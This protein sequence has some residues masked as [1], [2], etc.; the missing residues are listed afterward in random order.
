VLPPTPL[1]DGAHMSADIVRALVVSPPSS[2]WGA[3]LYLLDQVAPLAQRGI[4]LTLATPRDSDFARAWTERGH[5]VHPLPLRLHQGLR[6]P[7]TSERPGPVSMGKSA[8][9]VGRG[10]ATLSRVAKR[11]DMM[12]SFSLRTHLETA[13]AG[14]ITRTPT[15]LDLVDM[16]EP[17]IGQRVLRLAGRIATLTVANSTA[18]AAAL[19]DAPDVQIIHPAIDL[20]RFRRVDPDPALRRELT[21]GAEVPLVAVV[22]RLDAKKGIHVLVDAMTRLGDEVGDAK[23]VVVGDSGTG[24]PQYAEQLRIDARR[25]LGRRVEFLGRRSDIEEIMRVVD[26]LVVASSS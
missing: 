11:Y 15:A 26:V 20:H 3:Q 24:P 4:E 10:V 18:T 14:R 22:G 17:G 7:G 6:I 12:Y 9:G 21:G 5:P 13:L 8:V 25:L 19:G 2:V 1:P 23:L 16:V